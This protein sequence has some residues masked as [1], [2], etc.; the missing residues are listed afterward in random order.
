[1]NDVTA[2]ARTA[3]LVVVGFVLAC[4][5]VVIYLFTG[6]QIAVPLLEKERT[7]ELQAVIDDI[8]NLVPAGQVRMAGVQVGE[9]RTTTPG[10]D[11]MHVLLAFDDDVVPLHE[12]VTIRVGARSLVGETYLAVEDG[13]GPELSSGAEVPREAV[14]RSVDVRDVVHTF[15]PETRDQLGQLIRTAGAGT[16][17][18]ADGVG[19]VLAGLGDLGRTGGSAVD[20]IAAQSESLRALSAETATLMA[21]LDEGDGAISRMVADS[22]RITEATSGQ[23]EAIEAAVRALPGVLDSARTATAGLTELGTALGPVAANLRESGAP[24]S[25]AL[26]ELPATTAD[27]RGLLPAL[28]GTLDRT[29]G[30]LDRVP[31]FADD[32]QTIIPPADDALAEVGPMLHYI[33]PYGPEIAGFVAN[34]NAMLGYRDEAGVHYARLL[35]LGSDSVVQ[36]PLDTGLLNYHNPYPKPGA[37]TAPGPFAG[38]YPR[39]ERA[40]R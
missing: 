13:T 33:R 23:K 7:Y 28:D 4:L 25:A 31:T 38:D 5:A 3:F 36:S 30:T 29:P 39:I 10:P 14:K 15:D 27:L 12:G 19:G 37:G 16:A 21:A 18:T 1:M 40:P 20:A 9:V 35:A 8:D 22:R 2:S 24:L 26:T 6:T 17:G 34:F 11:G 32:V